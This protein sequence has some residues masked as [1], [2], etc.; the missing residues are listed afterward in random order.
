[1]KTYII[2]IIALFAMSCQKDA[3]CYCEDIV[4]GVTQER[5]KVFDYKYKGHYNPQKDKC[6]QY[7][8]DNKEA[9]SAGRTDYVFECY[10]ESK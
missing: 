2:L 8:K 10:T 9:K 1:M 3:S 5:H 7:E 4:G 6:L